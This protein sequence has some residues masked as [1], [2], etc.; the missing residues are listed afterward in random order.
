MAGAPAG[1]QNARNGRIWRDTLRRALLAEDAKNLRAIADA[2]VT[3]ATEGDVAAIREIGD[4][5]DGK[6]VQ[7]VEMGGVDGGPIKARLEVIFRDAGRV[8]G[9]T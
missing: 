4:R 9:E 3:K 5:L 8:P 7:S 6:A 2:L 1:N